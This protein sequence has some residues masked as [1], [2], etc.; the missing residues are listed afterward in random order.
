MTMEEIQNIE[1][2]DLDAD[3]LNNI[4]RPTKGNT[5]SMSTNILTNEN[6]VTPAKK[7]LK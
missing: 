4:P 3:G 2:I 7:R 1:R 5:T 6:Y